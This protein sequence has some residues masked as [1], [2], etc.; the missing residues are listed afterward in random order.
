MKVWVTRAQPGAGRTADRLRDAGLNPLVAPLLAVQDLPSPDLG[1]E[2][3]AA[4]AFTSANAV[5]AF[6]RRQPGGRALPVFAVGAATAQSAR[7]AG[8]AQVRSA[9]G[10][11]D[12]LAASI[13]RSPPPGPVLHPCAEEPAGD[14]PGALRACGIPVRP[15]PVYR[16]VALRLPEAAAAAWP[17]LDA[18]L[19]HSP[20]AARALAAALS[21]LPAGRPF[22][23][24]ISEAA[25]APLRGL[26]ADVRTAA[27]PDEAALLTLLGKPSRP[28]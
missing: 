12:A 4:L 8:F 5:A 27:R 15:V 26:L 16:T 28:G 3:A 17:A 24:C 11:V 13:R 6:A 25:A 19:I 23:A 22:T 9:D 1:L 7:D 21:S 20:R 18:V 10:D 14:L 2:G